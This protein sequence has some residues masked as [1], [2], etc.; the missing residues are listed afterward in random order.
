MTS[1]RHDDNILV[2]TFALT[3][4]QRRLI[5]PQSP[6]WHQLLY[7]LSGVLTVSTPNAQWTLPAHRAL[8]VPAGLEYQ[9]HIASGPVSLRC[10]YLAS[11][12]PALSGI[13]VLNVTPLLHA[14]ILRSSDIGAL[15]RLIPTQRRLAAVIHDELAQLSAAPLQLP[16]PTDPRARRFA[17][18]IANSSTG[19][20]HCDATLLRRAAVSRRTLERIF[21]TETGL[22]L[23]RWMRR[24]RLLRAAAQLAA[25]QSVTTVADSLGYNSPS[26]FVAAFRREMGLPPGKFSAL[27]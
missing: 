8:W 15:S 19:I 6:Y 22:S 18:F 14:L 12:R 17:S 13:S 21:L 2:R 11:P 9:L 16:M 26:S 23:G 7:V 10:L 25:G 5:P 24:E 1:S 3:A 4:P 27:C 20:L